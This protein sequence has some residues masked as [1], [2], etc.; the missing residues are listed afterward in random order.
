MVHGVVNDHDAAVHED[1]VGHEVPIAEQ[2]GDP[3]REERLA[4]SG[5]TEQE[6]GLAR[7]DRRAQ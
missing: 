6:E 7:V 4:V 3:F 1:R 2:T 5:V